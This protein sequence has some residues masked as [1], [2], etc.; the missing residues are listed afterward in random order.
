MIAIL[1][2]AVVGIGEARA[3]STIGTLT[4]Q[5]GFDQKL[6]AQVPLDLRFRDEQGR[7]VPLRDYFGRRPVILA[8]VYYRCPLLCNQVL[9]GLT[10][11]LKPL[12]MEAGSE[13]D[14]VAVSIDPTDSP[15][16]AGRKKENYL[17][18]YGHPGSGRGWHFLVGEEGSIGEL[19][20]TVGFRFQYNP[21]TKLYAHAA[22]VVI[23]TPGGRVARYFYGIEYPPR[24]VR[25][26]L[27]RAAGE[28]IGS[29]I[30]RLLLFCY[31]YDSA[32]GKYT[33]SIIR[34][35]RVLGTLTALSVGM[36]V[37]LMVRRERRGSLGGPPIGRSRRDD[38]GTDPSIDP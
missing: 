4:D 30:A 28:E 31:D 21:N 6:G 17:E 5:V 15:E 1:W 9:N 18:R 38:S 35:V 33:L 13:F 26:E 3:Q 11:C 37:L 8:L 10:R 22:G 16:V 36:F 24:E 2:L 27:E 14:V 32:T 20:R 23:L 7:M 34:L 25:T 29:P 19:S 12:P